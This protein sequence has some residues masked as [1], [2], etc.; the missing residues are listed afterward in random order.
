MCKFVNSHKIG[1]ADLANCGS[2]RIS[3]GIWLE[4]EDT[5]NCVKQHSTRHPLKESQAK[6]DL[7]LVAIYLYIYIYI[8]IYMIIW[9]LSPTK[10]VTQKLENKVL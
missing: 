10:S 8:Y 7:Y 9:E 5:T 4:N 3:W 1:N 6:V 2:L